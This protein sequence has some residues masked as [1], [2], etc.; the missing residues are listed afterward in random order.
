MPFI[1]AAKKGTQRKASA[2]PRDV[3]NPVSAGVLGTCCAPEFCCD[4]DL[5]RD[6]LS[7]T[8][9]AVNEKQISNPGHNLT[10]DQNWRG[11]SWKAFHSAGNQVPKHR[12]W[13]S[14]EH[15]S[16]A[17]TGPGP[18]STPSQPAIMGEPST[19]TNVSCR[20]KIFLKSHYFNFPCIGTALEKLASV[21]THFILQWLPYSLDSLV[22]IGQKVEILI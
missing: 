18:S 4:L 6:K 7:L 2:S 1:S 11:P 8:W 17:R 20:K 12:R 9:E 14:E 10:G 3:S 13:K 19:D 21:P 5:E 15:S 22:K 16:T